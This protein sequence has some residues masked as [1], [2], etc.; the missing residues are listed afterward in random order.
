MATYFLFYAFT[1]MAVSPLIMVRFSKFKIWLTPNFDAD[2]PDVTVTSCMTSYTHSLG[3]DVSRA[4]STWV[5]LDDVND[6]AF[7]VTS[8]WMSCQRQVSWLSVSLLLLS[9][10]RL[11]M[12]QKDN[13]FETIFK[14]GKGFDME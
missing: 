11:I 7:R 2:L 10:L 4:C 5:V 12:S 3:N 13:N 14:L 6:V 1:K 9:T 8:L